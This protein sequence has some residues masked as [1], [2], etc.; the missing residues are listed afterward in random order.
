MSCAIIHYMKKIKLTQ[1]QYAIVDDEDYESIN[2]SA[3]HYNKGYAVARAKVGKKWLHRVV[4]QAEKGEYVDH[5]NGDPLDNRRSN[6]RI[7]TLEQNQWNRKMPRDNTT[8]YKNI[9]WNKARKRFGVAYRHNGKVIWVGTYKTIEEA[10]HARNI[11]LSVRDKYARD[12]S[13]FN[14]SN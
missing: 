7:C 11:V 1:D 8:G 3:W 4:I 2:Q 12:L 6:L 13:F 9:S 10:L 5:I 14:P